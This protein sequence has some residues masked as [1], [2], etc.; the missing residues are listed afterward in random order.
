ME[1]LHQRVPVGV[2]RQHRERQQLIRRAVLPDAGNGHRPAVR[3]LDA[4][5]HGLAGFIIRFEEIGGRDD[6]ELLALPSVAE[7]WL[8]GNRLSAGVVGLAGQLDVG[9]VRNH[10]EL[11][12]VDF[13]LARHFVRSAQDWRHI[14]GPC[15]WRQVELG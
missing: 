4:P 14:A 10:A 5:A 1:A 7:G 9:P 2:D 11:S 3:A 12:R 13:Q 6:A 8:A 15:L